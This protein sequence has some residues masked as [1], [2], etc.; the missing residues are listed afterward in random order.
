MAGARNKRASRSIFGLV[1]PSA[2][3]LVLAACITNPGEFTLTMLEGST[4]TLT[5]L[6]GNP[7]DCY[8][9]VRHAELRR[10]D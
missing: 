10:C 9:S 4:F 8:H 5:D 3:I 6:S 1:V 7:D 2:L